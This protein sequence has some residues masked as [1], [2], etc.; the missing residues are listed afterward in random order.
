MLWPVWIFEAVELLQEAIPD[1]LEPYWKNL[2]RL[3]CLAG[4]SQ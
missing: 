4:F 1:T 3:R 2:A